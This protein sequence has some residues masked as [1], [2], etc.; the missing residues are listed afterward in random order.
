M[1][2]KDKLVIFDWGGVIDSHNEEDYTF[3]DAWKK[4]LTR[5]GLKEVPD[6]YM[7]KL[8]KCKNS[9]IGKHIWKSYSEAD[10]KLYVSRILNTFDIDEND[11][12]FMKFMNIYSQEMT[13]CKYFKEILDL[14]NHI[15]T[16]CEIGIMSNLSQ[17]DEVRLFS[18]INSIKFDYVWLSYKMG[19]VKP[20]EEI[21]EK[22]L[23]NCQKKV[24]N[25]LIIDD[26]LANIEKAKELGFITCYA[27]GNE[28]NKIKNAINN[29]LK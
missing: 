23:K 1:R 2:N 10:L 11:F 6:N 27:S 5:M 16:K 20:E 29:F 22:V 7:D 4:I 15:K 13:K 3:K 9:S 12:S 18:Q 25:I 28:Y 19:N 14:A 26:G 8:Y 24:K 17:L 21:Y